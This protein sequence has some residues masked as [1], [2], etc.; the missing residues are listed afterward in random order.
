LSGAIA[1]STND[2]I[3]GSTNQP[4]LSFSDTQQHC[5]RGVSGWHIESLPRS[6][7]VGNR[8]H[9]PPMPPPAM[10]KYHLGFPTNVDDPYNS[11][12]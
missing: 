6:V 5:Q 2:P 12:P 7:S 9:L 11:M 10:Q 4:S 8:S 1:L 3:D